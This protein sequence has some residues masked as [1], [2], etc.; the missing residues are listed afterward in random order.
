MKKLKIVGLYFMSALYILAGINHFISPEGYL[1]LIPEYFPAH[2]LINILAGICEV[3]FGIALLFPKTRGLASWGI[4][5]MLLAF[6]PAHIY[7][8]QLNS[9]IENGICLPPWTGWFRLLII[10]PVLI[11]WAYLY[12]REI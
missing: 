4:I 5:L 8:I 7:F 10:H 2:E 9:C 6:I 1:R 12:T 11:A 3:A